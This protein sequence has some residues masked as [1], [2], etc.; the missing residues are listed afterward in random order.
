MAHLSALGSQSEVGMLVMDLVSK[1]CDAPAT[2]T[3]Q[4]SAAG[5]GE[6]GSFGVM[7][8]PL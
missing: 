8:P 5:Q 7:G 6:N 3:F 4:L 2:C 1:I